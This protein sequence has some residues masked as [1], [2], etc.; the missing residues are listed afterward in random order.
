MSEQELKA[1]AD[2]A[3]DQV[4]ER[5]DPQGYGWASGDGPTMEEVVGALV[6]MGWQPAPEALLDRLEAAEAKVSRCE[7][8][9]EEA[10]ERAYM[11]I[12]LEK[13]LTVQPRGPGRAKVP[14]HWREAAE[15]AAIVPV[16]DLRAALSAPHPADAPEGH[17]DADEAGERL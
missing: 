10:T 12:A 17:G 13:I 1:L 2:S 3:V 14:S 6:A 15:F 9:A 8:L 5:L 4:C 7:A 11:G 16:D